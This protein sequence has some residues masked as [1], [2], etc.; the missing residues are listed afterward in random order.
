MLTGSFCSKTMKYD[1]EII[2]VLDEAGDKGLSVRKI[3]RHV[4]NRCNGLF[5]TVEYADVRRYVG[6]YLSRN[7]KSVESIIERTDVRGIYRINKS[8]GDSRQLL[9]DFKKD[10]DAEERGDK[11]IEDHSLSLF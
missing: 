7:C 11:V 4:F 10:D 6:E 2:F 5:D 3:A 1:R 9:L 8:S